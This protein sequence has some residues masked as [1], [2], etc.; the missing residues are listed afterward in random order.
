MQRLFL[1]GF[2]LGC[3]LDYYSV[4]TSATLTFIALSVFNFT[5]LYAI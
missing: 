1:L 4:I 3:R 5:G 2:W